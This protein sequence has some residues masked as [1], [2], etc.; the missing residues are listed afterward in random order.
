MDSLGDLNIKTSLDQRIARK[1]IKL[2]KRKLYVKK[3]MYTSC[4]TACLCISDTTCDDLF[5]VHRA[6]SPVPCPS[7]IVRHTAIFLTGRTQHPI[8]TFLKAS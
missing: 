5:S 6:L 4:K 8:L 1:L 3:G 2:Q 7:A